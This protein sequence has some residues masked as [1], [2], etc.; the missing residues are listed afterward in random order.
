MAG[1][2]STEELRIGWQFSMII[3]VLHQKWDGAC[4]YC[5]NDNYGRMIC[6]SI[7]A[8]DLNTVRL[9]LKFGSILPKLFHLTSVIWNLK[10]EK[11][12]C[13]DANASPIRNIQRCGRTGR[14]QEGQIVHILGEGNEEAKYEAN[15]QVTLL[16]C[17]M[18]LT[19]GKKTWALTQSIS[20]VCLAFDIG[21]IFK[22]ISNNGLIQI[23]TEWWGIFKHHRSFKQVCSNPLKLLLSSVNAL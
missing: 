6:N 17:I 9:L 13:F 3:T 5:N 2:F 21:S 20:G 7:L 14:H 1:Q 22:S 18:Y 23:L 16:T 11:V 15:I 10:V 12:V 8:A 4:R 19:P